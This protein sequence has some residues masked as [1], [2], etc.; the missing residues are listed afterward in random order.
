MDIDPECNYCPQCKG[1]YRAEIQS[2]ADC[3]LALVSGVLLLARQEERVSRPDEIDPAE[4]VVVVRKGPILQMKALQA[5]LR[6]QGLPAVVA[7]EA[8]GCCGCRGPEVLLQ[9]REEDLAEV[10]AALEREYRQSTG[11]ADHDA[12]FAGAVCDGGEAEAVCPA[13][14]CRFPPGSSEC[15]DCGLCFA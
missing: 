3:G 1:E 8:G 13:C 12:R 15:P 4:P 7:R 5:T 14:G 10:M 11:L 2:C 9:V 6:A